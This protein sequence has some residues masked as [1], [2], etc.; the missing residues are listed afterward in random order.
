[1]AVQLK[2]TT[3]YAIPSFPE[4]KLLPDAVAAV[5]ASPEDLPLLH[6]LSYKKIQRLEDRFAV[7]PVPLMQLYVLRIGDTNH[8][9][10]L[11]RPQ[12]FTELIQHSRAIKTLTDQQFMIQHFHQCSQLANRVPMGYL[13][14]PRSLE[15]LPQLVAFIENHLQPLLSCGES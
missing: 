14:R 13:Q 9:E 2:T 15:Q 12:A 6:S 4:V 11:P 7:H 3:P 5:N 10:T 1:M 8:I